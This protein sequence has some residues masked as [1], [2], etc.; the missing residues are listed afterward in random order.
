[1]LITALELVLYATS[2]NLAKRLPKTNN[3]EKK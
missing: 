1:M 3:K 2:A